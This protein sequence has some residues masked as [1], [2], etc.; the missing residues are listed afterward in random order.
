MHEVAVLLL[1]HT[2]THTYTHTHT[3]TDQHTN[4]RIHI[5]TRNEIYQW[6]Y[7][8]VGCMMLLTSFN[9]ITARLLQLTSRLTEAV[10]SIKTFH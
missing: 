6:K 4:I 5:P 9:V 7:T 8:N 10:I 1:E 2:H 3:H